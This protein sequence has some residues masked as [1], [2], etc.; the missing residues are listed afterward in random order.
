LFTDALDEVRNMMTNQAKDFSKHM[1]EMNNVI[2]RLTS[3]VTV[4]LL[5]VVEESSE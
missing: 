2:D 3:Q 4:L 1:T 5:I